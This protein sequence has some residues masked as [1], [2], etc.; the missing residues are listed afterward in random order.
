MLDRE[1]GIVKNFDVHDGYG[2]IKTD[3][4][5]EIYVHYSAILCDSGDCTLSEG[6]TVE[7]TLVRGSKGPQAQDVI[8]CK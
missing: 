3:Q 5:R 7:F 2:Y 1:T 4:G 8:V 6:D